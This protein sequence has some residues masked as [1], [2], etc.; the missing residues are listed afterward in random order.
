MPGSRPAFEEPGLV[1]AT[2]A[3]SRLLGAGKDA[4]G[5]VMKAEHSLDL[6][7]ELQ[8]DF[9][10]ALEVH[11]GSAVGRID[12]GQIGA[13]FDR[14]Y[15]IRKRTAALLLQCAASRSSLWLASAAFQLRRSQFTRRP[16]RD[17]AALCAELLGAMGVEVDILSRYSHYLGTSRRL[18][19]YVRCM[20]GSP[21]WGVGI[22]DDAVSASSR[23]VLSAVSRSRRITERRSSS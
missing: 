14:E 2:Q 16:H 1:R 7:L 23:A 8:I 3:R 20:A 11:L 5:Y 4:V 6:P 12:A 17:P 13:I 18:A 9:A 15:M 21:V 10:Q 19:V 22:A